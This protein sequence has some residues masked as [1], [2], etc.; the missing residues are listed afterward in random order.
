MAILTYPKHTMN[1]LLRMIVLRRCNAISAYHKTVS[2][3]LLVRMSITGI[4]LALCACAGGSSTA[5]GTTAGGLPPSAPT[6]IDP[7]SQTSLPQVQTTWTY[8]QQIVSSTDPSLNGKSGTLTVT[9]LGTTSYRGAQYY[10]L[11]FQGV[12]GP[13][14][15]TNYFTVNTDSTFS[16][17]AGV[18]NN[19]P[20]VPGCIT[21]PQQED[22]LAQAVNFSAQG[23]TSVTETS[24]RCGSQPVSA[25]AT[26]QVA[27]GGSTITSTPGGVYATRAVLGDFVT[28][29]RRHHYVEYLAGNTIIERDSTFYD[30]SGSQ[31]DSTVTK[32]QSGP[33]N[34][35]FPGLSMLLAQDW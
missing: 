11:Q 27:A 19:F 7:S 34:V 5:G 28:F 31:T 24:Y 26:V 14:P 12:A 4:A 33:L 3:R 8:A 35:A 15:P 16:E 1:Y 2:Q 21:S 32:Y 22:V 20:I 18:F 30:A 23:S 6:T 10:T 9:Y 25:T 13:P 17:Y 29:G